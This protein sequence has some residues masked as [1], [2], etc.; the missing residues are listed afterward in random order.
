MP[1]GDSLDPFQTPMR[2]YRTAKYATIFHLTNETLRFIFFVGIHVTA[3][4][5]LFILFFAEFEHLCF[6]F[7]CEELG[8]GVFEH[9]FVFHFPDKRAFVIEQ[10]AS[11]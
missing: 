1:S 5:I 8:F 2:S 7:I 9:A 3:R 6:D 10:Q 11:G 4:S